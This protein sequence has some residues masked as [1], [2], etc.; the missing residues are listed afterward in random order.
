MLDH[1]FCV[2]WNGDLFFLTS[3]LI[4]PYCNI[5]IFPPLLSLFTSGKSLSLSLCMFLVGNFRQQEDFSSPA[6]ATKL[7]ASPPASWPACWPFTG[8]F[9]IYQYLSFTTES[10]SD[11]NTG[12][13][14][15]EGLSGRNC[16]H[17]KNGYLT[18]NHKIIQKQRTLKNNEAW[19]FSSSP[20]VGNHIPLPYR[21]PRMKCLTSN[22]N[23]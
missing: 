10:K 12:H 3:N 11:K 15:W 8:L 17:K 4:L 6:W 5:C 23:K 21:K 9:P 18:K 14:V 22:T 1:V 2:S 13:E 20:V 19:S 7:S 16:E